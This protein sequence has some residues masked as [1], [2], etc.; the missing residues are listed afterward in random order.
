[1]LLDANKIIDAMPNPLL[2]AEAVRGADGKISDF[3]IITLNTAFATFAPKEND[4]AALSEFFKDSLSCDVPAVAIGAE[5]VEKAAQKEASFRAEGTGRW[6]RAVFSGLAEP[7]LVIS[8]TDITKEKNRDEELREERFR[9]RLTRLPSRPCV[10]DAIDR[11]KNSAE[12]SNGK[13][14][15]L[16]VDLDNIKDINDMNGQLAGDEVIT[17]AADI[18][19]SFEGGGVSL[20]NFGGDEF[21]ML[22]GGKKS[23]DEILDV[24]NRA[25]K[26]LKRENI[27]A[28]GGISFFPDHTRDSDKLVQFADMAMEMA[29]RAGKGKFIGFE[30]SMRDSL[31]EKLTLQKKLTEATLTCGFQQYYQPQFDVQTGKLRGFEALIRWFDGE[32]FIPPDVFIPVAE[33]TRLI[34]P[35]GKWVVNTALA[36]LKKWRDKFG[37]DGIMSINVSPVQMMQENFLP[38]LESALKKYQVDPA[39]VEVE[40]TEG[41]MIENM[42]LAIDT[43]EKIKS[44]GIRI[45]L[46]DF[47]TGYSSLSYLQKLP[48]D[49]LKIDK[50]FIKGITSDETQANITNAI[51][52]MVSNMG[53]DT[54]AEGVEDTRQLQMLN[55]FHC[56]TTQGFLQGKPMTKEKCEKYLSGDRAALDTI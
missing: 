2:V 48:L 37:F 49:T 42:S 1:M 33:E 39:F 17:R 46:D 29:K 11:E 27:S 23:A 10:K 5:A 36:S 9:D 35:I 26:A 38:G 25:F 30:N 51:I 52:N 19:R 14:G 34:I 54:I 32:K 24:A 50:S 41:V 20:F 18:L 45:S 13:F 55:R 44:M 16:V 53:L 21:L 15:T 28:S 8:L 47:G 12:R 6:F 7:F 43:L 31:V 22:I 40:V 56:H 3:K 4:S